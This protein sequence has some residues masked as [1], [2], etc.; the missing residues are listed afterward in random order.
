[1]SV[2]LDQ[3]R[4]DT[5]AVRACNS[6]AGTVP[7]PKPPHQ[8][9]ACAS[10][11]APLNTAAVSREVASGICQ[12]YLLPQVKTVPTPQPPLHNLMGMYHVTTACQAAASC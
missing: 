6:F 10:W 12:Q 4:L 3:Q 2:R 9:H 11:T 8:A 7:Q 5:T 1:M